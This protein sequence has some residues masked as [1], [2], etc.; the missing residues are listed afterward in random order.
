MWW[1]AVLVLAWLVV[2]VACLESAE[3]GKNDR[4]RRSIERI[5]HPEE[6]LD[7]NHLKRIADRPA[8]ATVDPRASLRDTDAPSRRRTNIVRVRKV[9]GKRV[10][11]T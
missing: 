8:P 4:A 9:P 2:L 7:S 10:A 3:A 11:V 5:L 1:E 6:G